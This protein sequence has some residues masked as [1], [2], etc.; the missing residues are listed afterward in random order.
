M[1]GR[2]LAAVSLAVLAGTFLAG[3]VAAAPHVDWMNPTP[4]ASSVSIT[5]NVTLRFSQTM[6]RTSVGDAIRIAHGAAEWTSDHGTLKW[7]GASSA[8]DTVVFNPFE[9][10]PLAGAVTVTLNAS[11]ARDPSGFFLDGDMDGVPEGSPADDV[12][13]SFTTE[14]MDA[15]PP[16]AIAVEPAEGAIQVPETTSLV[17]EFS[18]RMNRTSVEDAFALVSPART[19]TKADGTFWWSQG[20]DQASY[21]PS[22]NLAFG[23]SYTIRLA[24]NATDVNGNAIDGNRDGTGGDDFFSPFT[25]RAEPDIVPPS[26]TSTIPGDAAIQVN[27]TPTIS[28]TFDDAMTPLP[29]QDAISMERVFDSMAAAVAL[30][31]FEWSAANHTVSFAPAA[32]LAWD[33]LY[34]VTIGQ[35]ATDDAG[36]PLPAP[37]AFSFETAKWKGRV[38]GFVFEDD[39]PVSGATVTLGNATT[40]TNETGAFEFEGVEAGTYAI[41]VW[42]IGYERSRVTRTLDHTN[43][44]TEDDRVIDLGTIRLRRSDPIGPIAL[45]GIL[46][47]ALAVFLAL[48]LVLRRRRRHLVRFDE[49]E[50]DEAEAER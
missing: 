7:S 21:T 37:H 20:N 32:V 26:V 12:T 24:A 19:W 39:A 47:G 42:K 10:W 3:P 35:G 27:R 33:A 28:V 14:S 40:R 22:A 30:G 49:L 18:E 2:A 41:T 5:E 36:L 25:T 11:I 13:W 44:I 4:G 46:G 29:T 23:T 38:I 9:N 43:A 31:P 16:M 15:T 45:A 34:R 6:N 50:P 1:A 8:D 48:G 17:V